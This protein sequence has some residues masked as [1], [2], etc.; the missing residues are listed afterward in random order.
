MSKINQAMKQP[1]NQWL[2]RYLKGDPFVWAIMLLL[3]TLSIL[4]VYSA[5]SALAYR[6]MQGNTEY[7]LVKHSLLILSGLGVMWVAHKI[8]YRYYAG[9]S[10]LALW[11]SVPLLLLTWRYGLTLNEASRWLTIPVINKAFQPSDL[12]Q[13]ALIAN[14]A[15]MLAKQQRR[16]GNFQEALMPMLVWCGVICG[17]IA[18]TNLSAALLLFFICMLLMYIGRMPIKYLMMLTAIGL[19]VGCIAI[20]VG[21]RGETALNR[22]RAFAQDELPFQTEQACIA[23]ATGGLY[24]KGPGNSQQRNFLPHP[25]SDFIYAILVEE[26]GLMGGIMVVLLYMVLLYRGI[27]NVSQSKRAYGGLLSAG[28][29]FALVLQALVNMGVAVGLGPIT[30][31]PLPFVSMGGTSLLFTGMAV[32]IILSVS[33]GDIDESIGELQEQGTVPKNKYK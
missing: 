13:L 25:Y 15:N 22:L 11:T 29:S 18:L 24:G 26:Y 10:K 30:G 3:T 21:Q 8:D 17:L 6:K 23:I 2:K 19:A 12:A 1:I 9:L 31:L 33:R 27:R 14:L 5:A 4:T 16:I 20:R 28:L 7:Y 32:G